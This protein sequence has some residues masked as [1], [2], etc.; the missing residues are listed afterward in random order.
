MFSLKNQELHQV[1]LVIH[2]LIGGLSEY[3][4]R[5]YLFTYI[6]ENTPDT[7]LLP[8][9]LELK[10]KFFELPQ[11]L[12]EFIKDNESGHKSFVVIKNKDN[13]Y[14]VIFNKGNT[15]STKDAIKY[16]AKVLVTNPDD[17]IIGYIKNYLAICNIYK[18]EFNGAAVTNSNEFLKIGE[19]NENGQIPIKIYMYEQA[20]SF[21]VSPEYEVYIKSYQEKNTP[22]LCVNWVMQRLIK[23]SA[24]I[25]KIVFLLL[26]ILTLISIIKFFASRKKFNKNYRNI[27]SLEIILYGY[28]FMNI[29]SHSVLGAI[30]D[31][32]SMPSIIT[33]FIGVLINIY[34][35]VYKN[36]YKN[37]EINEQ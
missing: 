36:K 4:I 27:I 3:D 16:L 21:D 17:L 10:N 19:Q 33:A 12:Q 14:D 11:E 25:I 1:N 2:L 29:L 8:K 20:N 37:V 18:I 34:L 28:S 23:I 35:V 6:D 30:I 24:I 26:P 15:L 9:E 22:I 5:T 31:R 32:Y 7:E 13:E